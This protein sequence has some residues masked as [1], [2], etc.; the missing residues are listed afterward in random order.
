MPEAIRDQAGGLSGSILDFNA[1]NESMI[2]S[3][4]SGLKAADI[5]GHVQIL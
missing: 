1:G 2:L 3:R 4:Y 5:S